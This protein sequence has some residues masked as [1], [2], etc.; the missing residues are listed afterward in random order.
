[1]NI[2][3]ML[4]YINLSH[5]TLKPPYLVNEF[6]ATVKKLLHKGATPEE[7]LSTPVPLSSQYQVRGGGSSGSPDVPGIGVHNS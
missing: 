1:M 4:H 5:I 7:V 2:V 3:K 6:E